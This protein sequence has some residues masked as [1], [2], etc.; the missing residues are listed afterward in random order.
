MNTFLLPGAI[1]A[2]LFAVMGFR[3]AADPLDVDPRGPIPAPGITPTL[4][5]GG[6]VAGGAHFS[7]P[8][9]PAPKLSA[10][11]IWLSPAGQ[12]DAHPVVACFRKEIT[13]S[14]A[15]K[16]VSA[17][18][19]ADY[20]YRLYVNGH[21]VSRGPADPGEDYP[22]GKSEG[23]TGIY[24]ADYRDL[25]SFFKQGAN[26][27]AV[28]VFAERLS[29]WYGSSGQRGLFFQADASLADGT[30]IPMQSD[31]TWRGLAGDYFQ[32]GDRYVPAKEP[33]GWRLP[34]F[35]DSAWPACALAGNYWPKLL[36]S[37]LPPPL[38]IR[39]PA[40]RA[41]RVSAG[42]QVP[43]QP[44]KDG[45]SV[46]IPTDASFALQFDRVLSGYV[47]LKVKGGAGATLTI[48]M[49]EHNDAGARR[50]ANVLLGD[51][52]QYFETPFY[53]SFTFLNIKATNVK[54][55]FEI[56]D[57]SAIVSTYPVAYKGSFS[58]SDDEINKI[59]NASRWACQICMQDHYLDSPDHQEPICDPGDYMIESLIN[60]N[61]F[62]EPALTRQDLRKFGAL[63][64]RNHYINFHTSYALL[65][66]QMLM[67]YWDYTGDESLVREL[68][69]Q[70]HGL[71]DKF[72]TWR[73]KNGLISEAP[74]Y[75][76]MDWVDIAGIGCH[77][78]PAVI[79]QGYMTAFYYQAI[80]DGRRVALLMGD[81]NRAAVYEKLRGETIIAFNREL[82]NPDKGLYRDGKPFQTSV[83]PGQWLPADTDIETFSPHVNIL[84]AL[85]DLAPADRKESILRTVMAEKPL[86][87]QP[88]F[89]HFV[90][91]SLGQCWLFHDYGTTQIRRW[92]V[93]PETQSFHEM[94][95]SGD[96]S[97]A[98]GG[99]PLYQLST[100]VLGITPLEPGF[101]E[102]LVSPTLCDL[103][104]AKG[105]VP[106]PHGVVS[107]SWALS[108][109]GLQ[110]DVSAPQDAE[111]ALPTGRFKTPK[112]TMDGYRVDTHQGTAIPPDPAAPGSDSRILIHAAAGT[113]HF[114]IDGE[115]IKPIVP[116]A[117]PAKAETG[118][119]RTS[120][121]G[122]S[123]AAFEKDLAKDSL[124]SLGPAGRVTKIDEHASHQGGG[125]NADALRNGTTLNGAG[126]EGTTDDG[127]TFRGYGD[128]DW[129][130]FYLDTTSNKTGYDIT[131]IAT[132]AGHSD[133]RS[134]QNYSVSIALVGAPDKFVPLIESASASCDS[135]SSKITI[136]NPAGGP[137]DNGKG[138]KATGVVAIR[139]DF[140]NGSAESGAGVGFN[141]Y[142]EIQVVG[143]PGTH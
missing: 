92:R 60:F 56:Q 93:T 136:A 91:N 119:V 83:K 41:V 27:V 95:G 133:S 15:P 103:A 4:V 33:V 88:Y 7:N 94:W 98:W 36:P 18:I 69:P 118:P 76:F 74:D 84:A 113:H 47:G 109:K 121:S 125:Q 87:C 80:D 12:P 127:K 79:G 24:F 130:T 139:F 82:W 141:V 32:G 75:M 122:D 110:L 143:E 85:Y 142:R 52:L 64:D 117:P 114:L 107:V 1:L 10:P 66:F 3:A 53:G 111:V 135:G 5:D 86:N 59:W 57:V 38:E 30:V 106:T 62:G 25:A 129:L 63:L 140:K 96:L 31:E 14:A 71:L 49:N 65:W 2:L 77:H 81:A 39:Y 89:M 99:T 19:S 40:L 37:D 70:V 78:P 8:T 46:T 128:G 6:V 21:L 29:S 123:Q 48:G 55:P 137:I 23:R 28:E 120:T 68:A 54:T 34:G 105:S 13:L 72:A 11:W 126:E 112:V 22:G 102:V 124:V 132:L 50:S 17:W 9:V 138:T 101:P 73:G 44:F 51:G 116:A 43:A 20:H 16:R 134:S 97:H 67:D 26:A 42:L 61:V 100:R 108:E 45:S 35:D 90:L 131:K 115:F 58:C 104:W